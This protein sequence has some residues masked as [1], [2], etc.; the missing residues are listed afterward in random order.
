[1]RARMALISAEIQVELREI[2]LKDKPTDLIA[3]SAKATVPVLQLTNGDVIDESLQIMQWALAQND[4]NQYLIEDQNA[5]QLIEFNDTEFKHWL[6]KYKYAVRFPEN[7]IAY[8]QQHIDQCLTM[9]EQQ[10]GAKRFLLSDQLTMLD[11]ALMPFIRQ[12]A[13]VDSDWFF[14]RY[15]DTLA[16]WLKR[17]MH[18]ELFQRCMQKHTVW[19]PDNPLTLLLPMTKE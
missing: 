7:P 8:Y 12:C 2:R 11:L 6:D 14:N 17:I 4:P 18:S 13:Y 5:E 1:M 9:F 15:A 19:Q 10:L 3:L 16:P